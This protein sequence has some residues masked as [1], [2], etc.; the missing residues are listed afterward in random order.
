MRAP[1]ALILIISLA[2]LP[3][4]AAES[5]LEFAV[6]AQLSGQV[7]N[8]G[9]LTRIFLVADPSSNTAFDLTLENPAT[10]ANHTSATL[11]TDNPWAPGRINQPVQAPERQVDG[12]VHL[13]VGSQILGVAIE[14]ET[15][16]FEASDSQ[17]NLVIPKTDESWN[18]YFGLDANH[19][20]T[21][22]ETEVASAHPTFRLAGGPEARFS[23][24]ASGVHRIE[25]FGAKTSC[26]NAR[27]PCPEGGGHFASTINNQGI[28]VTSATDNFIEL[29]PSGNATLTG[30]GDLQFALL[31]GP[32]VDLNLNGWMRLPLAHGHTDCA[33]CTLP[34]N[35]TL[36]ATGN[37][38]LT[39]M[40][41]TG[42]GQMAGDFQG[43]ISTLRFDEA[44]VSPALLGTASTVALSV[45][46]AA[47]LTG[48]GLWFAG[49]LFTRNHGD[50]LEHP[51]RRRLHDYILQNPGAS[52]RE[53]VRNCEIAAGTARHHLSVLVRNGVLMEKRHRATTRFFENHGRYTNS[54]SNVVLLR[55]PALGQLHA[56]LVANPG[57]AQKEVLAGM[58]ETQGWSR[59]TTQHRLTRLLTGGAITMR[60]QGRLC[61]YYAG[62]PEGSSM[63]TSRPGFPQLKAAA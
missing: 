12:S 58:L 47:G 43:D 25:W 63:P 24:T 4:A 14:A 29:L 53:L 34:E 38:T 8:L 36:T 48:L 56:W 21:I 13:A 33:T 19:T 5:R 41:V 7:T 9:S 11:V 26:S 27:N 3:V 18:S 28:S 59:S 46:A 57:S 16:S 39:G 45:T 6:P 42:P 30:S 31:A 37:L 62:A 15:I 60:Y 55:E 61:I 40:H 51:R 2:F 44:Q 22:R 17:A 20:H 32:S 52:F 10:L 23:M 1:P 49:G 54:W 50:P 35:Q